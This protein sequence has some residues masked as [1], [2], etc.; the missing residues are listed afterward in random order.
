MARNLDSEC[1]TTNWFENI[2]MRRE[3]RE[4]NRQKFAF[5]SVSSAPPRLCGEELELEISMDASGA[6]DAVGIEGAF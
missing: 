6:E 1:A 2:P 3:L 4:L 5:L